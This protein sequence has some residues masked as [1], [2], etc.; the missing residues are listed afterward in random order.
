[1]RVA[2]LLLVLKAGLQDPSHIT[3]LWGA[4]WLGTVGVT[5]VYVRLSEAGHQV[6]LRSPLHHETGSSSL[7]PERKPWP[8]EQRALLRHPPCLRPST[9]LAYGKAAPHWSHFCTPALRGPADYPHIKVRVTHFP[10][11]PTPSFLSVLSAFSGVPPDSL[12]S[13]SFGITQ[14]EIIK[15]TSA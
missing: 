13:V 12:A 11:I 5:R 1:M 7:T 9:S 2:V 15:G 14:S 6:C 8:S 10:P 3:H 4:Q